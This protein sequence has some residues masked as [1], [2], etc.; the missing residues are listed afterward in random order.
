M[1]WVTARQEMVDFAAEIYRRGKPVY[2][3]TDTYYSRN[4]IEQLFAKC[5]ITCYT[6]LLVSSEYKTGKTQKLF[7]HLRGYTTGNSC[8]HIG[9]DLAVDVESADRCRL[10]GCQI[11]SGVDL[12]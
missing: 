11:Y 1:N 8:V 6:D 4:Q 9:D 7:C 12:F 5:G 3:T 10:C 2:I